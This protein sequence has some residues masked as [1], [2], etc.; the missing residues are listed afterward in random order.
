MKSHIFSFF[1]GAGF[2]DLGFEKQGFQIVYV[3]EIDKDFLNAYKYS[4]KKLNVKEP[5]Y[6]YFQGSI[7]ELLKNKGLQDFQ[8][9]LKN[10]KKSGALVGFIGGPPCP[11][12]SVAGKNKGKNGENG[13]L[14]KS[15]V[16]LIVKTKPD[17]FLFE[18]VKGLYRT[19]RHREFFE[20]LKSLLAKN[21]Y[22]LSERLINSIEYGAPQDRERIILLGFNKQVFSDPMPESFWKKYV[23]YESKSVFALPW[24]DTNKQNS[25]SSKPSGIIEE[26]TTNY[27]F[28]K[29]N[30]KNHPNQRHVFTPRAA[31][32]KFKVIPEGDVSKKSFKRLHN[33]RYSPTAAYGNNEVHIHPRLPRRITVA[34]ALAIQSLPKAFELPEN[35]SLTSMF[36]TIGNGVPFEAAYGIAK[37]L[38]GFI[39]SQLP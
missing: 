4:R 12:F 22:Y 17:F 2:L 38:K 13:K 24:P 3:N 23:K 16:D 25:I 18:N 32:P 1:S 26:L 36:K 30:V 11:D 5:I 19:T 6:G 20:Q 7:T 28:S 37:M 29:N 9:L 8:K 14:S 31:L 21:G 34:E 10:S 15:Y 35:M 39:R 33:H 27:W